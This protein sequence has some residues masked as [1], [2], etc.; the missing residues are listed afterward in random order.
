MSEF[1]LLPLHLAVHGR[2]VLV[3]GGGPVA[4]RKAASGVEAGADVLVVAPY[5][6][7]EIVAD[8]AA[9]LLTWRCGE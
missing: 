5:A 7:E 1:G 2:R 3:V 8:A 9:G 6:C 4:A